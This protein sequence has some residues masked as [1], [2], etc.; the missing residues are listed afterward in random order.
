MNTRL[1][2]VQYS[3]LSV[4]WMSSN[5]IPSACS[6]CDIFFVQE[7][8]EDCAVTYR[9]RSYSGRCNNLD[10]AKVVGNGNDAS[11]SE[12]FGTSNSPYIRFLPPVYDDGVQVMI[13]Q[14]T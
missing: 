12:S 5:Q 1:E 2:I 7:D 13:S 6:T 10:T 14:I 11:P 3:D 8:V 4:I 9:Y